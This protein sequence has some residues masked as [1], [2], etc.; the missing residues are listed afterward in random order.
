MNIQIYDH[1]KN[2]FE[3]F[4]KNVMVNKNPFQALQTNICINLV[5]IIYNFQKYIYQISLS[6]FTK[7]SKVTNRPHFKYLH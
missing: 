1:K 2:S 5:K 4:E 3:F 7:L 6:L